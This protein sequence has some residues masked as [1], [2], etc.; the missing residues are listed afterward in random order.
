MR[1]NPTNSRKVPQIGSYISPYKAEPTPIPNGPVHPSGTPMQP[2]SKP[3]NPAEQIEATPVGREK[4]PQKLFGIKEIAELMGGLDYKTVYNLM[5]MRAIRAY[6]V[7]NQW[8]TTLEDVED[9][10]VR[11]SNIK[12][13]PVSLQS[14]LESKVLELSENLAELAGKVE[15]LQRQLES[16]P[17][18]GM[19][20]PQR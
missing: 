14:G 5:R 20:R 9:Y 3:Y 16:Y 10:L 19:R 15:G 12:G 13:V 4:L 11:N 6:R 17:I 2:P 7:G 1:T 8:M 18:K